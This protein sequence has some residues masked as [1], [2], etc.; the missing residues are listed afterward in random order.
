[1]S[2]K[3]GAPLM[4]Q[5]RIFRRFLEPSVETARRTSRRFPVRTAA[6]FD[7]GGGAATV[8][9]RPGV[10]QDFPDLLAVHT[11]VYEEACTSS[12][13][14]TRPAARGTHRGRLVVD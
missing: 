12:D 4:L 10:V 5:S 1:M 6:R 7:G 13:A 3:K 2:R 11:R 9:W 8:A 14:A